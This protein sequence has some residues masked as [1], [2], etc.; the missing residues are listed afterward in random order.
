MP[1][2]AWTQGPG[3]PWT[4][5]S[6]NL[7][8]HQ[9]HHALNL[10]RLGHPV[11]Y[12][13]E[14][15]SDGRAKLNL[16]FC[17]PPPSEIIPPPLPSF[18]HPIPPHYSRR[19]G[20][21]TPPTKRPIVPLFPPGEAPI[22][23]KLQTPRP[24]PGPH[25]TPTLS[26]KKRKS[27][28]R[29]VLHRASQATASLPAALPGTLHWHCV[30]LLQRAVA[31]VTC[32][33][34]AAPNPQQHPQAAPN[35]PPLQEAQSSG[36]RLRSPS[37]DTLSQKLRQDFDLESEDDSSSPSPSPERLREASPSSSPLPLN[38]S[39]LNQRD[40]P[41]ERDGSEEVTEVEVDFEVEEPKS[42]DWALQVEEE[43]PRD[44]ALQVEKEEKDFPK[45][46]ERF[47][48]VVA[49]REWQELLA[50]REAKKGWLPLP[51]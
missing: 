40:A 15:L 14:S 45:A 44:W 5:T 31:A 43:K 17:L 19:P 20:A 50:W 9:F 29:A 33:Q 35:S 26:S 18:P 3:G 38:I 13:L 22:F 2:P 42:Q 37:P 23:P 49:T 51:K 25:Q 8:Q 4:P 1:G 34:P 32:P 41:P 10:W 28:R 39:S 48:E 11:V 6:Q 7:V 30:G 46:I 12:H 36:K 47:R 16:T 27:Y 24:S 21:P